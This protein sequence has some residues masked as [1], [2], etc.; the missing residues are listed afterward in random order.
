MVGSFGIELSQLGEELFEDDQIADTLSHVAKLVEL[1]ARSDEDFAAQMDEVAPRTVQLLKDFLKVV[2]DE[3]AGV[4]IESGGIRC[5]L[6]PPE[7]KVAFDL[8]AGTE[9]TEDKVDI[10]GF[11]KGILLESWRYDFLDD[12]NETITGRID[13]SVSEE[14]ATRFLTEFVNKHCIATLQLSKV[15][16]KNGRERTNYSLLDLRPSK[17]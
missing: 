12:Q 9:T 10:A 15:V 13:E 3:Q 6:E 14:R 17:I 8:V 5:S 11:F 2:A 7:A 16:F 4:V 1:S